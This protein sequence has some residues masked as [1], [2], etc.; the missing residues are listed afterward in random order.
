[1]SE[2]K[3]QQV[4][5]LKKEGLTTRQI[6]DKLGIKRKTVHVY[7]CHES[8]RRS[9]RK[10]R[11]RCANEKLGKEI[12]EKC[13]S[14]LVRWG[15]PLEWEDELIKN[16]TVY[17]SA[18]GRGFKGHRGEDRLS[19]DV[20]SLLVLFCRRYKVPTPNELNHLT[21]KGWGSHI[22]RKTGY[23]HVLQELDGVSP[24]TPMDYIDYF[25]KLNKLDMKF[26]NK[27]ENVLRKIAKKNIQG[28]NPRTVV[29]AIIYEASPMIGN[30]KQFTQGY[31]SRVLEITEVSLRNYWH[32]YIE[33]V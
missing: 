19:A 10:W 9:S 20:Q 5:R 16:A 23:M 24:S 30:I 21:K 13:H 7:L 14:E 31:I 6:A 1:M 15:L 22:S 8:Q 4:Q 28:K 25:V 33:S 29:A 17:V 27:A 32:N 2:F 11:K 3:W 12:R 26:R 18:R